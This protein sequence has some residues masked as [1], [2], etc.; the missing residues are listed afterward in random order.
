MFAITSPIPPLAGGPGQCR[1]AG[2]RTAVQAGKDCSAQFTDI[3]ISI[4]ENPKDHTQLLQ[5]TSNSG[6]IASR[7]VS[8]QKLVAFLYTGTKQF[9]IF[10]KHHLL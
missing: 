5:L 10:I 8:I 6:R 7:K 3:R 4:V 2:E 9:E 1:K